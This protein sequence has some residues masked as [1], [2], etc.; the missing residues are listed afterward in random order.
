MQLRLSAAEVVWLRASWDRLARVLPVITSETIDP[1]AISDNE[2][3]WEQSD[4]PD[5]S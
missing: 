1:P 3:P 5:A 4:D 2:L